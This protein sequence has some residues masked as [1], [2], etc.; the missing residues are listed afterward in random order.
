[1]S[2]DA[3]SIRPLSDACGAEVTNVDLARISDT[4]LADIRRLVAERGVV[5]VRDQH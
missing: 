1:M 4:G 3:P 5:V 2:M